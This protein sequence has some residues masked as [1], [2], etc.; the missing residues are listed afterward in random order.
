MIRF[1]CTCGHRFEVADDEAGGMIQCTRCGLLNDVPNHSDLLALAPDG[2]YVLDEADPRPAEDPDR[3][4]EIRLVYAKT[5]VDEDGNEIDLRTL[6]A[7]RRA[8][9]ARRDVGDEAGGD[10]DGELEL[11][12]V[13][14]PEPAARVR[15]RYDPETGEL[16]RPLDVRKDPE[17]DV[18]P[19]DIPMAKA[20]IN[21]ASAGMDRRV[22]PARVALELLMPVNLA[23]LAVVICM[24]VVN[25][26]VFVA[27][28][29]F[30][31]VW[32]AV[33]IIQALQLAHYGNVIDDTGRNEHDDLPRP[34][35]DLDFH[36]DIWNP[37]VH[38][39]GGLMLAYVPPLALAGYLPGP[40]DVWNLVAVG[41]GT[42]LTPAV[43]LTTN[44]SGATENLRPDRVLGV[45]RAARGHYVVAVLLWALTWP[46]YAV[47][48]AGLGLCLARAFDI[49]MGRIGPLGNWLVVLPCLFAGVYLM[50]YFGWFMGLVYRAHHAE[51]PWVL[52][53][54]V[55]DPKSVRPQRTHADLLGRKTP[56]RNAGAP[57]A[58]RAA[59]GV[60]EVRD[61]TTTSLPGIPRDP[62]GAARPVV[63]GPKLP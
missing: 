48:W 32:P 47:G 60:P 19:A 45:I 4:S 61:P 5:K 21:Y 31:F 18:N 34:L 25:A 28:M 53:H 7:G 38:M 30:I 13:D 11:A 51:F 10:D 57:Q 27:A 17:R 9:P 16:I 15:P 58:G 12:P 36:D 24:H 3:M 42:V 55:R 50:H 56:R 63:R 40:R 62:K 54:F 22:S 26:V 14:E 52:Q 43:L 29:G 39:F 23:V 41:V 1:N 35:R 46:V 2:T 8:T 37:F 33:L 44:T 49:P 59:P 20:A 6:P